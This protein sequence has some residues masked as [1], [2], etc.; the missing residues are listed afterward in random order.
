MRGKPGKFAAVILAGALGCGGLELGATLRAR[1]ALARLLVSHPEL[2]VADIVADP[3]AGRLRLDGITLR[4]TGA[5]RWRVTVG[6][7][8]LPIAGF[9]APL[10]FALASPAEAAPANNAPS[11]SAPQP[12]ATPVPVTAAGTASAENIVV[13]NGTTTYRIKRIDMTGT[14]LTS[15]DLAGLLDTKSTVP[16]EARLR[17]LSASAIVMPE[18]VSEDRTP[19]TERHATLTQVLLAGVAAGKVAAGSASGASFTIKDADSTVEGALGTVEATGMDLGQ[20]AHVLGSVFA[21]SLRTSDAEPVLSLYDSAIVNNLTI[22]NVTKHSTL[23]L[24]SIQE[25]G[26]KGRALKTDL[27]AAARPKPANDPRSAALLDDVA[28][29]FSIGSLVLNDL[30]S[31][32]DEPSGTAEF[33]ALRASLTNFGE[34]KIGGADVRSFRFQGT[35]EGKFALDALVIGPVALPDAGG[36]IGAVVPK[37]GTIDAAG[38]NVDLLS[39][40]TDEEASEPGDAQPSHVK[41][42]VGHVVVASEGAG[43]LIPKHASV[44]VENVSFDAPQGDA[45]GVPLYDMGYRHLD[46]SGVLK[47]TYDVATQ[48]LAVD[49][50]RVNGADMGTLNLSLALSNVRDGLFSSDPAIAQAAMITIIAKSIDLKLADGGLLEKAIAWK[51]KKDGLTVEQERAAGID[52][53]TNGVPS[54][55]NDNPKVKA[56]GA[57]IA[58]FVADPGMLD[59]S[60]ASQGGVGIAAIGLLATP[61]VLIDTLDIKASNHR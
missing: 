61:E 58:G 38:I 16:M 31:H 13:V 6:T 14:A 5:S 32:S 3:L 44:N 52:F 10:T 43:G 18:I 19:G 25:T 22:T 54:I 34:G 1:G 12:T 49:E 57:A 20:V 7:L 47:S 11:A 36:Q 42:K 59:V 28:H 15:A 21:G 51:A 26:A 56:L 55:V 39:Q 2:T 24:G 37:A 8:S 29:S 40:K 17:R 30:A 60:I 23:T 9:A 46:M 35:K 33:G 27:A 4:G 45:S 53:F 41:F 50:L 48:N